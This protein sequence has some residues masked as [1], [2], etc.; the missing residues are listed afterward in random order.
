ML[1]AI[2]YITLNIINVQGKIWPVVYKGRFRL[3]RSDRFRKGED[4]QDSNTKNKISINL[5]QHTEEQ[6]SGEFKRGFWAEDP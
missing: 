2:N 4:V 6:C 1:R 5:K 3:V